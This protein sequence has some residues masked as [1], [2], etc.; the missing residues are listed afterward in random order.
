MKLTQTEQRIW[1]VLADGKHH[2]ANELAIRG[3]GKRFASPTLIPTHINRM[4]AKVAP[5][6][7]IIRPLAGKGYRAVRAASHDM[8]GERARA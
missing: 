3:V 5:D 2:T 4:R 8:G 7:V 1:A 6:W